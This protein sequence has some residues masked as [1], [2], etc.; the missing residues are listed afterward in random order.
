MAESKNQ[1]AVQQNFKLPVMKLSESELM[2]DMDGFNIRLDRLVT[3]SG[4]SEALKININGENEYKKAVNIIIL[5]KHPVNIL[6]PP[7]DR[8][9]TE[10]Q[11]PLC[12]ADDGHNGV[13]TPGGTCATCPQNRFRTNADGTRSKNCK[14][15]YSLLVWA[16]DCPNVMILDIAPTGKDILGEYIVKSINQRGFRPWQVVTKLT[17]KPVVVPGRDPY[18]IP[19][20]E[21]VGPVSGE[22]QNMVEQ[23][24]QTYMSAFRAFGDFDDDDDSNTID[25]STVETGAHNSSEV[26]PPPS[27]IDRPW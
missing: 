23:K 4:G 12:R 22:L 18:S 19:Q 2:E 5:D 21:F 17:W 8:N 11:R 13:G 25:S 1:V 10:K 7:K 9:S 26:I 27:D 15:K 16:E 14:N 6:F 3:P 20:F 24:R